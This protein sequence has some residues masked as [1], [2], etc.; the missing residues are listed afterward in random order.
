MKTIIAGSRTI[1]NPQ[2]VRN[3]ILAAGWPITEVVCGGAR[4]VDDLGALWAKENGVPVK[5]M[6][7]DWTLHGK[8]AGPIRNDEMAKYAEA[9][10]AV[11]DG[12]SRGTKHMIESARERGLKVCVYE[13]ARGSKP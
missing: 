8:A 7:A 11:W 5:L 3:A 4:G 6:R 2:I 12:Q 1:T 10:I 13:Y 9:L